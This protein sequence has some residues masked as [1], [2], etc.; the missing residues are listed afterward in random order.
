MAF[1]SAHGQAQAYHSFFQT[2]LQK[3]A[4]ETILS[5]WEVEEFDESTTLA[6][7]EMVSFFVLARDLDRDSSPRAFEPCMEH[8]TRL[9]ESLIQ[10]S[11]ESLRSRAFSRWL[12]AK[13]AIIGSKDRVGPSSPSA[14]LY[15]CPGLQIKQGIGVN[16]PIYVPLCAEKPTWNVP[17]TTP[18]RNEALAVA[19]RTA[20]YLQDY[21][22]QA[23]CLKHLIM[24]SKDP[25]Q[26]LG[27]L[28]H[29]QSSVQDDKDGYIRTCLSKFLVCSD[30]NSQGF[31]AEELTKFD[32]DQ[33]RIGPNPSPPYT[34]LTLHWAS[35]TIQASLSPRPARS[36]EPPYYNQLPEYI[37][38]FINVRKS[39]HESLRNPDSRGPTRGE[40][41]AARERQSSA[42]QGPELCVSTRPSRVYTIADDTLISPHRSS[43]PLRQN[44]PINPMLRDR[45]VHRQ[46]EEI[47]ARMKTRAVG[48]KGEGDKDRERGREREKERERDRGRNKDG[49]NDDEEETWRA[50]L[51]YRVERLE[52]E[53]QEL[54]RQVQ[55][56]DSR[57]E[58]RRRHDQID[59]E[60]RGDEV[61]R[62]KEQEREGKVDDTYPPSRGGSPQVENAIVRRIPTRTRPSVDENFTDG[63]SRGRSVSDG[64]QLDDD[65]KRDGVSVS[66]D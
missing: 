19:L 16:I 28:C 30:A 1:A 63:G 5:D 2:S 39:F 6:L 41:P 58:E 21:E 12:A 42:D 60:P 65:D 62:N 51:R 50:R 31:L 38:D 4:L 11:P 18:E 9:V 46:N 64:G 17:D 56:G 7:L 27:E 37:Q 49:N 15:G 53:A 36:D 55:E 44:P 24:Q 45:N 20:K 43:P 61:R 34:N 32:R 13:A 25:R 8:G 10:N 14:F 59:G 29:L 40:Q 23:L 33:I 26:L 47:A 66:V 57:K 54:R 48:K 3:T 22:T 35:S 52:R